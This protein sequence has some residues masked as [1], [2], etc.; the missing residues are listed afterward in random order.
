MPSVRIIE[1]YCK[2]CG[3]CVEACKRGVLR[4]SKRV[5]R[6]GLPVVCVLDVECTGCGN[7]TLMCPDAAIELRP[8]AA[9]VHAAG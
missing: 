5:N 2:G 1:E 4:L 8:E 6:R 3:L 9:K 7:C